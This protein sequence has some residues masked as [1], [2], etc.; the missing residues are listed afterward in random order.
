M[1]SFSAPT[2]H[3]QTEDGFQLQQEQHGLRTPSRSLRDEDTASDCES[4]IINMMI[5]TTR[6]AEEARED[7]TDAPQYQEEVLTQPP[8]RLLQGQRGSSLRSLKSKRGRRQYPRRIYTPRRVTNRIVASPNVFTMSSLAALL[9]VIALVGWKFW[10]QQEKQ[11]VILPLLFTMLAIAGVGAVAALLICLSDRLERWDFNNGLSGGSNNNNKNHPERPLSPTLSLLPA[12]LKMES[13]S[14]MQDASTANNAVGD[15]RQERE[16]NGRS[17]NYDSKRTSQ[18]MTISKSSSFAMSNK[19]DFNIQP[20][21]WNNQR[22]SNDT[23]PLPNFQLRPPPALLGQHSSSSHNDHHLRSSTPSLNSISENHMED[24]F[25]IWWHELDSQTQY[26]ALLL[27]YT[28]KTWD[29]D[30]ELEDLECEDWDWN[31]LTTEQQAAAT[32][33]GYSQRDW[34]VE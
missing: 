31:Q 13:S 14:S 25:D 11:L 18:Q 12:P 3:S 32:Y 26:F 7:I 20:V 8:R 2:N 34:D 9:P 17:I 27:G 29:A 24:E 33:F 19:T 4:P 22:S 21:R 10:M 15:D 6:S 1:S 16:R 30:C 28:P 23:R 5:V